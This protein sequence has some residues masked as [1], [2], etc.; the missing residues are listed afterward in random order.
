[1]RYKLVKGRHGRFEDGAFTKYAPGDVIDLTDDE[2]SRLDPGRF[3]ALG[4]PPVEAPSD[5]APPDQP[6]LGDWSHIADEPWA[7]V[8]KT[9]R[10]TD[11]I[12]TLVAIQEAEEAG[13]ARK[14]VLEAVSARLEEL[15]EE[16]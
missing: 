4:D 12:E 9:I 3:E 6:K 2:L 14:G 1:M 13:K 11:D 15:A 16:D 8:A 5:E 7:R 10:A